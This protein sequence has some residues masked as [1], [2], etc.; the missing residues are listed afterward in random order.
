MFRWRGVET[1]QLRR[2]LA[3]KRKSLILVRG[4][5]NILNKRH[6]SIDCFQPPDHQKNG[7]FCLTKTKQ[8]FE[9]KKI[10]I[11]A[12]LLGLV[13]PDVG[14]ATAIIP[15][16]QTETEKYV[17][18]L[19]GYV[20]CVLCME[21]AVHLRDFI[22]AYGFGGAGSCDYEMLN[23][24][25]YI[26]YTNAL[27]ENNLY[28]AEQFG[29]PDSGALVNSYL[30]VIGQEMCVGVPPAQ[31]CMYYALCICADDHYPYIGE[32][33]NGEVGY[34]F[35]ECVA[36]PSG[37]TS[38]PGARSITSCYLP[39]GT[40]GSDASGNFIYTDDCHYVE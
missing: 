15:P 13:V 18:K 9:M 14:R 11:T 40:T 24:S 3:M 2:D 22:L 26:E 12:F 23:N 1:L 39:S 27:R 20:S 5:V 30:D 32:G 37:G 8:G 21:N 35:L 36:C 16:D 25:A 17:G 33:S 4:V 28:D 10:F 6:N 34:G 19:A 38:E 31:S 29:V 7:G